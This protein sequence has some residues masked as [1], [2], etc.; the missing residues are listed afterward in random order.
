VLSAEHARVHGDGGLGHLE[1]RRVMRIGRKWRPSTGEVKLT[2]RF[3]LL[4]AVY[5]V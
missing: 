2:D 5:H 1:G 3:L 4:A